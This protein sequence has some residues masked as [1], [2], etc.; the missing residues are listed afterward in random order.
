MPAATSPPGLGPAS[1]HFIC[2]ALLVD[3]LIATW[4]INITPTIS[5]RPI[6]RNTFFPKNTLAD[7]KI[8]YR[9]R[10]TQLQM[11]LGLLVVTVACCTS[12]IEGI[13]TS[14]IKTCV[15][16]WTVIFFWPVCSLFARHKTSFADGK[17]NA[18]EKREVSLVTQLV[19]FLRPLDGRVSVCPSLSH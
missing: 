8:W 2:R 17:D 4:R 16:L 19:S 9:M 11:S 10:I 7:T 14:Y 1:Q 13:T 15:L 5:R 18:P 6:Y 12:G 3:E